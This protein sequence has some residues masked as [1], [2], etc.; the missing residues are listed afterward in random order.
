MNLK[1]KRN[2]NSSALHGTHAELLEL[3]ELASHSAGILAGI[4]RRHYSDAETI[5]QRQE[6]ADA[7]A[8]LRDRF[9]ASLY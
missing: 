8:A 9:G 7:L 4:A 3:L 1:I 6:R 2:K 5:K